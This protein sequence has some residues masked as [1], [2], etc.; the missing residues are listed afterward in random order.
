MSLAFS[1]LGG[2]VAF[3]SLPEALGQSAGPEHVHSRLLLLVGGQM[4]L[5]K[6]HTQGELA[7]KYDTK[8]LFH[9]AYDVVSQRH[10]TI[11]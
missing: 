4:P 10:K 7:S 6:Q 3:R 5:P 8:I 2:P 9:L 1:P 11:K